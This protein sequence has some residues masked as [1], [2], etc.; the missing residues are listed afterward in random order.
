MLCHRASRRLCGTIICS[1]MLALSLAL[2]AQA[3]MVGNEQLL[4]D[5]SSQRE[6]IIHTLQREEIRAQL[7]EMG[8]STQ[9]VHQRVERLTDAE[10]A[11]L[12]QRLDSLPVGGNLSTVELLLI[13]L[14]IVL[15]V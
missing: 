14:L 3:G 4:N 6:A 15:L 13:I 12:H 11:R 9:N 8:V 10:V 5:A 7:V 1:F 2:P